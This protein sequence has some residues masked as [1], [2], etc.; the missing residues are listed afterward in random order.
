MQI[1]FVIIL[2]IVVVALLIIIMPK[3]IRIRKQQ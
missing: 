3:T 2:F 1:A